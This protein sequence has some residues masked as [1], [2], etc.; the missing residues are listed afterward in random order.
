M[1]S[2]R[3]LMLHVFCPV[4]WYHVFSLQWLVSR[5]F[6][7]VVGVTCFLSSGWRHVFSLQWLAS[8][9]MTPL[10]AGHGSEVFKELN[11]HR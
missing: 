2:V 6:S 4:V 1:V 9:I 11:F 10:M 8:G 3:W 7:P 5:V